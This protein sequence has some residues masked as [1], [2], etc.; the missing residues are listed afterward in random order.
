MIPV[1]KIICFIVIS[2]LYL[3]F[4][5]VDAIPRVA[6]TL[7]PIH[8]PSFPPTTIPT[9]ALPTFTSAPYADN[10]RSIIEVF[11]SDPLTA[12]VV[13]AVIA[14]V[15]GV[16]F[17]IIGTLVMQYALVPKYIPLS[18]INKDLEM[19]KMSSLKELENMKHNLEKH[20]EEED[21]I[22]KDIDFLREFKSTTKYDDSWLN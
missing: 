8:P 7:S 6:P 20:I 1:N 13:C 5:F 22:L 4:M 11:F 21:Q 17:G 14:A 9:T 12:A 19:N 2:Q 15:G 10:N 3:D 18:T 16:C